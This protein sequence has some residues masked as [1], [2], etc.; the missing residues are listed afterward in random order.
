MLRVEN[1]SKHF[2]GINT[3]VKRPPGNFPLA[4]I[5]KLCLERAAKSA[6][7]TF[8]KSATKTPALRLTFRKTVIFD[9]GAAWAKRTASSAFYNFLRAIWVPFCL[10]ILQLNE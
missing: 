2:W 10:F 1:L 3:M 9:V 8:S 5:H 7:C 4:S 6:R